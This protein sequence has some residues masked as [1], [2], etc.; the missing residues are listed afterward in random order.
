MRKLQLLS[1]FG[2][3]TILASSG[4]SLTLMDVHEPNVK[5]KI[6]HDVHPEYYE[7]TF[8]I[9]PLPGY[10]HTATVEFWFADDGV[11]SGASEGDANNRDEYVLIDIGALYSNMIFLNSSPLHY[12]V[13]LDASLLVDLNDDGKL[14]YKISAYDNPDGSDDFVYQKGKL[15]A[16]IPDSGATLILLGLGLIGLAAAR[17]RLRK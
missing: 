8:D 13:G 3:A 9:S 10:V 6:D 2:A 12:D 17:K 11:P 1:L 5:L 7:N 16:Y 15:T 14:W 4:M